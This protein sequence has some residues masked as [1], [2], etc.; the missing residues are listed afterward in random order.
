MHDNYININEKVFVAYNACRR[1]AYLLLF[2]S[3]QSKPHDYQLITETRKERVRAE[4]IATYQPENSLQ[5]IAPYIAASTAAS[6]TQPEEISNVLM[7]TESALKYAVTDNKANK[8]Q[9]NY[10]PLI[11]SSSLRAQK[12]DKIAL[13]F[14]CFVLQKGRAKPL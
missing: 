7:T 4:Y 12:E 10:A 14:A 9:N 5:T 13:L 2:E 11:F 1:K 6:T 8:K 3:N